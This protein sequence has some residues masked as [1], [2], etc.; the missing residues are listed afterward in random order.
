MAFG[1]MGVLE[2]MRG[3]ERILVTIGAGAVT[4]GVLLSLGNTAAIHALSFV[5]KLPRVVY[6][7]Y[8][9]ILAAGIVALGFQALFSKRLPP[10]L[11]GLT[12]I[13]TA[14]VFVA[15]SQTG[16][17]GR[18]NSRGLVALLL[19]LALT[20]ILVRSRPTPSAPLPPAVILALLLVITAG[21]AYLRFHDLDRYPSSELSDESL[22][23]DI[24]LEYYTGHPFEAT[25]QS[26]EFLYYQLG[27]LW[28]HLLPPRLVSL[29]L[30]TAL[31]GVLSVPMLYYLGRRLYDPATG[32]FAAALMT[33]SPWHVLVSRLVV[34]QN[35]AVLL[36]IV[37]YL[38]WLRALQRSSALLMAPAALITGLGFHSWV[39][40]KVVPLLVAPIALW[41]LADRRE[42]R[43]RLTA[44]LLLS[45]VVFAAVLILPFALTNDMRRVR[46]VV[47][48]E[49]GSGKAAHSLSQ[50]A[51]NIGSAFTGLTGNPLGDNFYNPPFGIDTP[52]LCTFMLLGLAVTLPGIVRRGSDRILIA[53]LIIH[54]GPA[55]LSDFPYQRR[56]QGCMVPLF[57]MGGAF[58]ARWL[59]RFDGVRRSRL[60]LLSC[61]L[62]LIQGGWVSETLIKASTGEKNI[63][64][65]RIR[66]T[67][68]TRTV[69]IQSGHFQRAWRYVTGWER[70]GDPDAMM[71]TD[72]ATAMPLIPRL[73]TPASLFC[74]VLDAEGFL[75]ATALHYP[76]AEVMSLEEP[77]GRVVGYEVQLRPEDLRMALEA[78]MDGRGWTP[79][80]SIQSAGA[81]FLPLDLREVAVMWGD[82]AHWNLNLDH[83]YY[84]NEGNYRLDDL[85]GGLVPIHGIP[86]HL[87]PGGV[88]PFYSVLSGAPERLTVMV[89]I[90]LPRAAPVR[91]IHLIGLISDNVQPEQPPS[92]YVD[93]ERA[94]GSVFSVTLHARGHRFLSRDLTTPPYPVQLAA[95]YRDSYWDAAGFMLPDGAPVTAVELRNASNH[96][97]LCI[98]G[99]TLGLARES[100]RK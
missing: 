41:T 87:I 67:L 11:Y 86:Y 39:T 99:V 60:A 6:P 73:D 1:G 53:M 31:F 64:N 98:A 94:D 66:D 71:W 75:Q 72:L 69:I 42:H 5:P 25:V 83:P 96:E 9:A 82:G 89:R 35:L 32:L 36:I 90:E 91:S 70:C 95:Q 47:K 97:S 68:G 10:L 63:V 18:L 59:N 77:P 50:I 15:R 13:T 23:T 85:A 55:V 8:L 62:I 79:G 28:F 58:L 56:L 84:R 78:T 38:L 29:R 44:G 61:G 43:L 57:I 88:V 48:G 74:R 2:R 16:F 3:G 12:G 49:I 14:A 54:L 100:A 45:V 81:C 4:A 20:A 21:A 76:A 34:R 17:G 92:V 27:R 7:P 65:R 26:K 46:F 93:L 30:L 51:G 40:F 80:T 19:C 33:I 52:M 22:N 37:A 24:I